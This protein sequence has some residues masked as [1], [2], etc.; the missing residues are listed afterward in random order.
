MIKNKI[1]LVTIIALLAIGRTLLVNI[2][3]AEWGDSYRILR[4]SN[5]VRQ[6]SYPNDE[7]RPP[8]FSALLAIRPANID[9]VLWGR[10]FMLATSFGT[11]FVFYELSKN[12]LA[13]KNQRLLALVLLALN[14]VYFYWSLRI[15]ADVFFSLLV[16]VCFYVFDL[17]RKSLLDDEDDGKKR[18]M[19]YLVVI[20]LICGLSVLT[21]FEGYLLTLAIVLGILI[22]TNKPARQRFKESILLLSATGL[23]TLPWLIY[24]NPLTS[25]YFEEPAGRKYDFEMLLTY[26]VSYLFVLGVIPAFSLIA[27]KLVEKKPIDLLAKVKIY[28]DL[29]AFV[30]L[31]SLLILAWPAAVPRLFVPIIPFLILAIIKSLDYFDD[32]KE[33]IFPQ[34][35]KTNPTGLGIW[36]FNRKSLVTGMSI[37]LL[38]LYIVVQYK[39]RLQFLGPHT[40]VFLT[41]STLGVLSTLAIFIKSKKLFLLSAISSMILLSASTVY[42]HKDIYR[43]IK[44]IS[45]F[46]LREVAGKCG[47]VI[48]NDTA[49][50]VNWYIP[51][52]DYKNFDNK[53]YLTYDYLTENNIDCLIITNEFNPNLEI[54]LTKRPHL[55]LIKESNYK[56][57]GKMFFT[58]LVGVKK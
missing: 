30:V 53:K 57:G 4:A 26:A 8:L 37:G 9:P 38:I 12:Y 20:G 39:L 17:W 44:E 35:S 42:L 22:V 29:N 19:F 14:P 41:I 50:I 6:L 28:P 5:Y 18:S 16:L 40:V 33:S 31:E 49:S 32:K 13:T 58:W 23:I 54:D 24:R 43:S 10:L 15:Y 2:N 36:L 25:S 56:R 55:T 7:K 51:K 27:N 3:S 11:L 21:R 46:S 47:K 52:S 34:P 45:V 48:H 1:L